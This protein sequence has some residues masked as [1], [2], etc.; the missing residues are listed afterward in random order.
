MMQR[1]VR[2][3][4]GRISS[5][6]SSPRSRH[7]PPAAAVALGSQADPAQ[8]VDRPLA[9]EPRRE[10]RREEVGHGDDERH[11]AAP[12]LDRK[13][14]PV[15]RRVRSAPLLDPAGELR[16]P[17]GSRT[18]RPPTGSPRSPARWPA[19]SRRPAA[20][21]RRARRSCRSRRSRCAPADL[22]RA[23]SAPARGC[24]A[25]R[26]ARP[27]LGASG[28]SSRSRSRRRSTL[29]FGRR[30]SS[31]SLT[32]RLGIMWLGQPSG[33]ILTPAGDGVGA[34]SPRRRPPAARLRRVAAVAAPAPDRARDHRGLLDRRETRAAPPRSRRA[35]CESRAA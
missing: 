35:R 20:S 33:Q 11:L 8:A 17:S 6:S 18:R 19:S 12:G 29:P 4:G 30:G 9:P 14:M 28:A 7:G 21:G 2:E 23:R 10:H 25:E 15:G 32:R 3:T 34:A 27:R 5:T 22:P 31:G 26:T 16:A 13:Q 1:L 24:S